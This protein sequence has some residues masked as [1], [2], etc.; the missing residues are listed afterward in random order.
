[1]NALIDG[2]AEAGDSAPGGTSAP[3]PAKSSRAS[4]TS[5]APDAAVVAAMPDCDRTPQQGTPTRRAK[6]R[7]F[8]HLKQMAS[9]DFEVFADRNLDSIAELSLLF[10]QSTHG[11]AGTFTLGQ[12]AAIRRR[13]E[14]GMTFLS[15][16][17]Q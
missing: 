12:L 13:V 2:G 9:P 4:S 14:G 6:I 3:A 15:R 8:L 1:M 16:L 7:Y 10:N 11:E 5:I 17:V